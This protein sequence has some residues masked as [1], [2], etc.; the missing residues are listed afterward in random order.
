[1]YSYA[2]EKIH[3]LIWQMTAEQLMRKY[4][5]CVENLRNVQKARHTIS[6]MEI[7]PVN[8]TKEVQFLLSFLKM[9]LYSLE[10]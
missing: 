7:C 9:N 6:L 10:D 5:D 1:M 4:D 8:F 3:L 2:I